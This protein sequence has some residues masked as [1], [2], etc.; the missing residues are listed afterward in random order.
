[1]STAPVQPLVPVDEYLNSSYRPDVEYVDGVLVERGMPTV[2]HSLL[3]RVLLLH[4][5]R[6]ESQLRFV[7]LHDVR[8]QI[9]GSARY[10][11]PD[12]L[13]VPVPILHSRVITAVPDVVIE[14]LSPD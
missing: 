14:V 9:T 6:F 1:M 12:V 5:V 8:T 10:R 13:L 3:Q 4:F 7:T 2:L 11:I